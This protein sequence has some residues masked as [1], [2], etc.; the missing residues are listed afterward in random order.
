LKTCD[1]AEKDMENKDAESDEEVA[2][3][4]CVP[5]FGEAVAGF[6]AVRRYM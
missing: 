2:E 6:E 3:L 5:T 4:T 1:A